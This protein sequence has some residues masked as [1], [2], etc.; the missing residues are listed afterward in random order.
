MLNCVEFNLPKKIH[1]HGFLTFNGEK[2][3]KSRGNI[4]GVSRFAD[5]IEPEYLRYY[6][7]CRINNSVNDID[8]S[9][10]DFMLKINS[11]LVG[12]IINL[13]SRSVQMIHK[14]N[15][16]QLT[17][18]SEEGLGILKSWQT[19][20]III[21]GLFEKCEFSKVMLE[22]REMA[23]TANRY[24]DQKAPWKIWNDQQELAT[25]TLCDVVNFARII[26]IYLTPIMPKMCEKIAKIF[27]EKP[28]TF[29]STETTIEKITLGEYIYL[30]KP[31]EKE[32]LEKLL[33]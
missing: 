3:S 23:E 20:K 21:K 33:A 26:A 7:A 10:D 19:K 30:G 17:T 5:L 25:S 16:S 32:Q 28:Y 8:F 13:F 11:E 22:I 6:Y 2:L 31:V 12:K 15:S 18:M 29:E 24:L 27:N 14:K 1:I 4:I 9:T